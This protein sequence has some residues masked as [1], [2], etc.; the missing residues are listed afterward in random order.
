[1]FGIIPA[2]VA[3]KCEI[4]CCSPDSECEDQTDFSTK[5]SRQGTAVL[6]FILVSS[7]FVMLATGEEG[8]RPLSPTQ[9]VPKSFGNLQTEVV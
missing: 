3:R 7:G 8:F 9:I 5:A 1:M 2:S 6:A 4:V